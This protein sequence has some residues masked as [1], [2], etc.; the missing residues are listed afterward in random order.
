MNHSLYPVNLEIHSSWIN[1]L[2]TCLNFATGIVA[3]YL[4]IP[5]EKY[6]RNPEQ[7]AKDISDFVGIDYSKADFSGF[8]DSYQPVHV[9]SWRHE[10]PDVD[11][12]LTREFTEALHLL[13]YE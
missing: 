4:L 2:F 13:G 10:L 11:Q 5:Y 9:D 8:I 1:R 7:L 6:V 12:H 3:P